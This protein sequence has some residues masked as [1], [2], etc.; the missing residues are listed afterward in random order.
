MLP[1]TTPFSASCRKNSI[2]E[3]PHREIGLDARGLAVLEPDRG[4]DRDPILFA[5]ER[6]DDALVALLDE[7][8]A[9]LAGAGQLLVV[10][11]ELLVEE[12]EL[13]DP[14]GLGERL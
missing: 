4:V 3:R 9:H 6:G 12:H 13:A 14:R 5:V 8:A 1:T 2:L 7:G 10:G 11:V